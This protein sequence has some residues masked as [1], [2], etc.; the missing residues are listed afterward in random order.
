MLMGTPADNFPN[1]VTKAAT[2]SL[3]DTPAMLNLM[4]RMGTVQDRIAKALVIAAGILPSGA[5][6][7]AVADESPD[8]LTA[9]INAANEGMIALVNRLEDISARAGRL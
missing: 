6:A 4:E 2:T 5:D 3:P 7:P 1:A 9:A 8:G